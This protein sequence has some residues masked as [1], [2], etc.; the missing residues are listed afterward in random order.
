VAV[1]FGLEADRYAGGG[2]AQMVLK[3]MHPLDR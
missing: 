3:D 2:A 1:A